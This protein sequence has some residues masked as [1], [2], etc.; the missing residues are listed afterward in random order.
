VSLIDLHYI[1]SSSDFFSSIIIYFFLFVIS[2]LFQYLP[3]FNAAIFKRVVE[4]A[5]NTNDLIDLAQ[6]M[7][8]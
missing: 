5:Q 6:V 3:I 7:F 8:K 1:V 2:N 4:I